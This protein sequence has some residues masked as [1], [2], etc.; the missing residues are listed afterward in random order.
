MGKSEKNVTENVTE[1]V[2]Q[3]ASGYYTNLIS[4]ENESRI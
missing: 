1:V 4:F 2:T 3:M